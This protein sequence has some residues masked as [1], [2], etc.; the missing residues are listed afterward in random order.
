M[1]N[2]T[3]EIPAALMAPILE[4]RPWAVFAAC[5]NGDADVFFGTSRDAERRALKMCGICTVIDDCLAHSLEARERFGLWGGKTEKA[6]KRI[7]REL[8]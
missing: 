5:R 4:E 6:R 1:T 2:D 8:G 3:A 7:L